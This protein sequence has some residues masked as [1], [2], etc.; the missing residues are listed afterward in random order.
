ML[1]CRQLLGKAARSH[2]ALA[3]QGLRRSM[4]T[5]SDNP[6]DRKVSFTVNLS[7]YE[8]KEAK[9]TKTKERREPRDRANRILGNGQLESREFAQL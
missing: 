4:A 7:R 9:R 1:A 3:T 5:V 8:I 6:L 2:G